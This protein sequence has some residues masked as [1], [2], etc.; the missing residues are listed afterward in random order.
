MSATDTSGGGDNGESFK[1]PT[2][3]YE[4]LMEQA[5]RESKECREWERKE[6]EKQEA[7]R[8]LMERTARDSKE[9][10]GG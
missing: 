4:K 1:L 2:H 9:R 8:E 7:N 6:R 10:R 3:E 5:A